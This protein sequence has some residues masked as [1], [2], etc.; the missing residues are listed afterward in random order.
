MDYV[1]KL[2]ACK[3]IY[4]VSGTDEL[5]VRAMK[6]N[7][8]FQYN[9]CEE[10]RSIL[11]RFGFS[12]DG[13]ETMEDVAC[14]P[15]IPTVYLKKHHLASTS[16]KKMLIK[17]TS[18]GTSSR[19]T[20]KIGLDLY[21]ILR[22]FKMIRKVFS[23]HEVWSLVPQRFV[24]FGYEHK[25]SNKKAVAQTAWGFTFTAPAL[26]KDYCIR[27]KGGEY[28]PDLE[29]IEKQLIKYSKG[30]APVR[31]IGFPAYTYFLMRQMRERGVSVKLPK[32]SMMTL[33]GGWKQ[34]Y[35]ERVEKEDFYR[36]AWE[37][38]GIEEKNIIEFFGA[39]EHPILWTDCRAHHFHI[40]AY[41]RVIIRDPD[42]LKPL[43][44]GEVG[45]INLV[46]PMI[47][48]CPLASVMTDDL[49]VIHEGECSCGLKTPY[50]EIIGRVGLEDIKTCA[51][52]AD[53][54]M[55]GDGK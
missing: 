52:G 27:Y 42:T 9:N 34:F 49:G 16:D 37:V 44:K 14:I 43:P 48:S 22:G 2:F 53:E 29:Y 38:L 30:R 4:D 28:V 8:I 35:A 31:T 45:L 50:L 7:V 19:N 18:S 3:D 47:R 25:F 26:S 36:L 39:A 10:Y 51:Q 13:I 21:S 1:K 5:F 33:G 54:L 17:A 20:S 32:G 11:D 12:P 23:Y 24:V 6:Q 15:P 46:T 55:K 40:P 41:A